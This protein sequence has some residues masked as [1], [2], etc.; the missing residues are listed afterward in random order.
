M[1]VLTLLAA[2]LLASC[3]PS[4]SWT[5]PVPVR[6]PVRAAGD[7]LEIWTGTPCEGVTEIELTL[8]PG[9][10]DEK[11]EAG[12]V[13]TTPQTV[14]R[15]RLGEP[16]QGFTVRDE[17][18]AATSWQEAERLSVTVTFADGRHH[19]AVAALDDPR[20]SEAGEDR[21]LLGDDVR[22]EAEVLAGVGDDDGLLCSPAP[23]SG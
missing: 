8:D 18:P 9:R 12:Y 13:A 17:L 7:Q 1:L 3:V 21:W 22:T 6:L 16:P 23:T 2:P 4:G 15:L 5:E 14:E 10:S 19:S 11:R 20:I